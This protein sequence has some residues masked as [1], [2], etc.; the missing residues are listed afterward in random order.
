MSPIYPVWRSIV[1]QDIITRVLLVKYGDLLGTAFTIE[2]KDL[3]Y[4][5]RGASY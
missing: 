5:V 4:R 3:Q 2:I 1:P